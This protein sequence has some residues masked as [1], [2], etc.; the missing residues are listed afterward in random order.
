[1]RKKIHFHY[2]LLIIGIAFVIAGGFCTYWGSS[3]QQIHLRKGESTND[4]LP[5]Q[6]QLTDFDIQYQDGTLTPTNFTSHLTIFPKNECIEKQVSCNHPANF[7]GFTIIQQ[8][9]DKDLQGSVLLIRHDPW[10]VRLVFSGYLL[11]TFGL[12]AL[13]CHKESPFRRLLRRLSVFIM[14]LLPLHS[15]ANDFTVD[16]NTANDFRRLSVYYNGRIAPF[17]SYA[18]DYCHTVFPKEYNSKQ[19]YYTQTVLDIYLFPEH[20]PTNTPR[21]VMRI[22]PQENQWLCPNDT[23]FSQASDSLFIAH[24]LDWLKLSIIQNDTAQNRYI[25]QSISLF[26]EQRNPHIHR[27]KEKAEL[28]YQH[29]HLELIICLCLIFF[30]LIEFFIVFRNKKHNQWGK[31]G[32]ILHLFAF[33]LLLF[34]L[35]IRSYISGNSPLGNTHDTMLCLSIGVLVISFFISHRQKNIGFVGLLFAG[36]ILLSAYLIEGS[37]FSALNAILQSPWLNIHVSITMLAYSCFCFT[38]L[39]AF[40]SILFMTSKKNE[41]DIQNFTDMSKILDILGIVFLSLG[42]MTGS[43]WAQLSWGS[44]WNWDPKESMALLTLIAYSITLIGSRFIVKRQSFWYHIGIIL[45][46]LFLLTTYFGVNLWFGGLHS[47]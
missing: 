29:Y 21:P 31:N 18:R 19:G 45:S 41:K 11:I 32:K 15:F 17:E 30:A 3:T 2:F 25:I 35:I 38:L 40:I 1:M 24:I 12:I 46:F 37:G 9:Y 8:G 13:L 23:S 26:Q 20:W 4:N 33:L 10:G 47:Y 22:F 14:L 39:L 6:I 16:P 44:Y 27:P 36:F 43:V 7:Q 5:F 28:F 42:I 34:D